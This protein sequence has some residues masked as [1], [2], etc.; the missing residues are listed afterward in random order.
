MTKAGVKLKVPSLTNTGIE[1]KLYQ[2][3]VV[4]VK[5]QTNSIKKVRFSFTSVTAASNSQAAY[6][7]FE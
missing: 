3:P 7:D 4:P 1:L 6:S 5:I 2:Y